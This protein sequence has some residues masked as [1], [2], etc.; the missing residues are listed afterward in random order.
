[1]IMNLETDGRGLFRSTIPGLHQ[2]TPRENTI[3]INPDGIRPGYI[4][5]LKC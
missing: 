2:D 4:T 5:T 3:S 1:M